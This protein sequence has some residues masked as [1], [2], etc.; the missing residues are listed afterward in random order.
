MTQVW[1][2]STHLSSKILKITVLLS[3]KRSWKVWCCSKKLLLWNNGEN[4]YHDLFLE[5]KALVLQ[6]SIIS[7]IFCL[8]Y[9]W[10]RH[11][12]IYRGI[13]LVSYKNQC[14]LDGTTFKYITRECALE[15][16]ICFLLEYVICY[17]NV[18]ISHLIS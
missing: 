10:A 7:D 4:E 2:R 11:D 14:K 8:F 9:Q 18:E 12:S 13:V 16:R 1:V 5:K 17:A 3:G 15:L 6:E